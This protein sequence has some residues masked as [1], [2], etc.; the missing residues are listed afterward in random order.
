MGVAFTTV[1]VKGVYESL[2]VQTCVNF[3]NRQP[4][5]SYILGRTSVDIIKCGGYKLSA[6]EIERVLLEHASIKEAA[7]VGIE[8]ETWGERVCL[9]G[10]FHHPL[11]VDEL[12][13]WASD[14]LAS[15]KIPTKIIVVDNELP[16]NQMGKVN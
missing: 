12:R 3:Q 15:Y 11:T 1:T 6:L 9:I 5:H 10:A 13:Q 4:K 16:K 14:K 2:V 8:D 7:V